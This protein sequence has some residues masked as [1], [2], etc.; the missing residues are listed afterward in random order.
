MSDQLLSSLFQWSSLRDGNSVPSSPLSWWFG[1]MPLQ[2]LFQFQKFTTPSLRGF[3]SDNEKKQTVPSKSCWWSWEEPSPLLQPICLLY[4]VWSTKGRN[5]II[6]PQS[7]QELFSYT[8]GLAL[9]TVHRF[10]RTFN[11]MLLLCYLQVRHSQGLVLIRFMA[12]T[13]SNLQVEM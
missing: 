4:G 12:H 2:P 5:Q 10:T 11:C 3:G 9:G 6:W 7:G 8:D 13:F 1:L